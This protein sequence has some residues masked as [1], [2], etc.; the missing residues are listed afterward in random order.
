MVLVSPGRFG[1]VAISVV[2]SY[3]VGVPTLM[4][5]LDYSLR[6]VL[7]GPTIRRTN[8]QKIKQMKFTGNILY[9][10]KSAKLNIPP[11]ALNLKMP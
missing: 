3:E 2:C 4:N 6:C 7:P 1:P 11:S 5:H 8:N 10:I 9:R